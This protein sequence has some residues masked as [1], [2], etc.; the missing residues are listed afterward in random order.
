M[1]DYSIIALRAFFSYFI[2]FLMARLMGKREVS[3][4]TFFDYIVG[5]TIGSLTA[6]MAVDKSKSFLLPL[7]ALSI[8]SILQILTSYITLK[9]RN[10]RK[11][12]DGKSTMLIENGKLLER[13]LLKERINI[14]ELSTML[15][16]K[17]IFKLSDVEFA[18]LEPDG[19]ISAMKKSNKQPITP[20]DI[21]V[22][23]EYSGIGNI[24]IEEGVIRHDKLREYN[25]TVSWLMS[26]LSNQG[27]DD[28]KKIMFAQVDGSGK[29]YV[30]L[31]DDKIKD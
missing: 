2:L 16:E 18:F 30:D 5:I 31:Y 10:F 26:Q 21:G 20:S 1:S 3:Q 6:S 17:N 15:R 4:M 11:I 29:L 8:F 24:V 7:I 22:L 28:I 25:L 13:N 14:D 27:I 19:K 9:N 12:F 23:T